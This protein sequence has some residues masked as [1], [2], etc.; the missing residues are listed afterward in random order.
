MFPVNSLYCCSFDL[1]AQP[2]GHA[3]GVIDVRQ[4]LIAPRKEVRVEPELHRLRYANAASRA[5]HADPPV[6]GILVI[7]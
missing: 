4:G 2:T 7:R 1:S 6:R 5:T 3:H